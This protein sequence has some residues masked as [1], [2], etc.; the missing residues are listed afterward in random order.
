M[1]DEKTSEVRDQEAPKPKKSKLKTVA[2]SIILIGALNLAYLLGSEGVRTGFHER[3]NAAFPIV[4]DV[5][6]LNNSISYFTRNLYKLE[7]YNLSFPEGYDD[8]FSENKVSMGCAEVVRQEQSRLEEEL[9]NQ[10]KERDLLIEREDFQLYKRLIGNSP[11]TTFAN[12]FSGV[13]Y[14]LFSFLTPA[15][16][17]GLLIHSI[18]REYKAK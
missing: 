6:R 11:L 2:K 8:V 4:G 18:N 1:T 3:I 15:L 13:F 9:N 7:E 17:L 12:T 14:S 16:G 10:K 5:N